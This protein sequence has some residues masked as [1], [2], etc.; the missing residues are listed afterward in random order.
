MKARGFR[1]LLARPIDQ[2]LECPPG[3]VSASQA[4]VVAGF[5]LM[6]KLNAC[7]RQSFTSQAPFTFFSTDLT[8]DHPWRDWSFS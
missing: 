5:G 7:P 4:R 2:E 1:L 6:S 3:P 8:G